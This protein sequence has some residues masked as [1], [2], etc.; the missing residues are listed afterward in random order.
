M[1]DSLTYNNEVL[2]YSSNELTWSEP[3]DVVIGTQTWM[4]KNIDIA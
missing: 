2:M 1:A 4:I 3:I